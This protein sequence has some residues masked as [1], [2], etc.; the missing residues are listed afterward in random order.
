ML[1]LLRPLQL[2]RVRFCRD[3]EQEDRMHTQ[4]KEKGQAS[5]CARVLGTVLHAWGAGARGWACMLSAWLTHEKLLP[6]RPQC[7]WCLFFTAV[8]DVCM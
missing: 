6:L 1:G 4:R 5:P 3:M 7:L 8:A 2:Q